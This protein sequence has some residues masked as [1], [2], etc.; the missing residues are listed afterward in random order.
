MEAD[1]PE[2][3]AALLHPQE[4]RSAVRLRR[5]LEWWK[6]PQGEELETACLISTASN[7]MMELIHNR[8]PVILSPADY[9]LWM[10]APPEDAKGLQESLVPCP[11]GDLVAEPVSKLANVPRNDVPQCIRPLVCTMPPKFQRPRDSIDFIATFRKLIQQRDQAETA[12][13][14][15]RLNRNAESMKEEWKDW[16][17]EDC[18]F[19]MAF[20]EPWKG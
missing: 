10:N 5:P 18:L 8:M 16:Q 6:S 9:D 19:E 17:G 1:R 4:G 2:G 14:K 7:K 13:E 3:K 11:E 15:N 20:G 12:S